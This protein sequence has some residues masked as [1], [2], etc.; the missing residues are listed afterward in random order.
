VANVRM[1]RELLLRKGYREGEELRVMVA[2]GAAHNEAA[3]GRRI[4][5]AIP[6]LLGA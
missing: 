4:K 2:A 3:W 6:Y 1:L 5:K